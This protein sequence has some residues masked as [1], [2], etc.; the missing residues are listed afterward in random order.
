MRTRGF[1]RIA[2]ALAAW[3]IVLGCLPTGASAGPMP[4]A[5]G[6]VRTTRDED[7]IRIEKILQDERIAKALAAKG[8][9]QDELRGKLDLMSDHEVHMLAERLETTKSGGSVGGVLSV[10]FCIYMGLCLLIGLSY[11]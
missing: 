1:R 7:I 8:I 6:K 3:A 2:T 9:G 11:M 5:N 4:S 10:L